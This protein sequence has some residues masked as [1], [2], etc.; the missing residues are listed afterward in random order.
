MT[1][2]SKI[3]NESP[4]YRYVIAVGLEPGK[5]F[6][7]YF[8]NSGLI[9]STF[10]PFNIINVLNGGTQPIRLTFLNSNLNKSINPAETLNAENISFV[11]FII[12]NVGSVATDEKIEIIIRR[13]LTVREVLIKLYEK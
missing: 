5:T 11:G 9:E 7:K 1:S 2:L 6:R 12:Q 8:P 3:F 10:L 13:E 4:Y